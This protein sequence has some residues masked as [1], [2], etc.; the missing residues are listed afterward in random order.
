M[1]GLN[2]ISILYS[3]LTNSLHGCKVDVDT[4][5]ALARIFL[6]LGTTSMEKASKSYVA[7]KTTFLYLLNPSFL[8]TNTFFTCETMR[9][10][11]PITFRYLTFI[12]KAK[13]N[14]KFKASY[15]TLL[16]VQSNSSLYEKILVMPWGETKTISTLAPILEWAPSKYMV[17]TTS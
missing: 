9:S 15:S 7:S 14:P 10:E 13:Y 1:V 8:A 16:L 12:Y 5:N 2:I 3:P 4:T 11:S 6:S 17:Q